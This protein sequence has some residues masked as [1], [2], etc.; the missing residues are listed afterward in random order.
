MEP[1]HLYIVSDGARKEKIGE[2]ILVE[3]CR[4]I[5]LEINWKCDVKTLFRDNNLGSGLGVYEGI[6]WFFNQG[7]IRYY[8]RR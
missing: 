8:L 4:E 5:V 1:T 2:T 3:K 6:S 7:D